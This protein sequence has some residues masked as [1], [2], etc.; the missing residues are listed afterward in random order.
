MTGC[1]G[2]QEAFGISR[3]SVALHRKK[4]FLKDKNICRMKAIFIA[5]S[6]SL[7]LESALIEP[8][9]FKSFSVSHIPVE[10]Y[11]ILSKNFHRTPNSVS[12]FHSARCHHYWCLPCPQRSCR[13]RANRL[14]R[15]HI[16]YTPDRYILYDFI[17]SFCLLTSSHRIF[18]KYKEA[19]TIIRVHAHLCKQ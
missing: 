14:C 9:K 4:T 8:Y 18:A 5:P 3:E 10:K 2:I 13:T 11:V 6:H 16:Q 17:S 19:L 7:S 15:Q 12:A 1:I